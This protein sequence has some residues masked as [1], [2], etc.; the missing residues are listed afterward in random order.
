MREHFGAEISEEDLGHQA[1]QVAEAVK[2]LT[3]SHELAQILRDPVGTG[4]TAVALTAARLLLDEGAVDYVLVIAPNST[5]GDQWR[6]RAE[7]IFGER[8]AEGHDA[9]AKNKV[10]VGTHKTGPSWRSPK[11][12]RSL[13]IV[14]EAHRG[15]QNENSE[16]FQGVSAA[17]A[18]AKTLLVTA[19]PYQ[20][21]TTGFTRMLG[22][23]SGAAAPPDA[24][25]DLVRRYG[26]A[27]SKLLRR[28]EPD[29]DTSD[30]EPLIAEA[31][32]CRDKAAGVLSGRLLPVTGIRVPPAPAPS[33]TILPLGD[34]AVPYTVARV[35]P[36][37]IG[38]GRTDAFQRSLASSSETLT[39]SDRVVGR[40][41]DELMASGEPEVRAFL[42]Q[43]VD[44]MGTGTDHP[45]EAATVKW[46]KSQVADGHHVVV[47]T[48]WLP[49]R[50]AIGQ[51]LI[52]AG[53]EDVAAP[54][55]STVPGALESRFKADAGDRPV[56]L[57]LSDRFSESIDLDGGNPSIVH[58]DLTW[59]PIRLTQRWGRVVRIR[60]GFQPVPPDRIFLP[61]LDV[62]V[63]HRL[64]RVVTGRRD[65]AGLVVPESSELDADAWTMPDTILKRIA[66]NFAK[67][68]CGST[69]RPMSQPANILGRVR[70]DVAL[71]GE[72]ARSVAPTAASFHSSRSRETCDDRHR[73]SPVPSPP[74]TR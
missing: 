59:N 17:A 2:R 13:V 37:M 40:R 48:S 15:L 44:R 21:T 42:E 41:I 11:P 61:I 64:A 53:M 5:V 23:S 33:P 7:P 30:I 35:L 52:E 60:T 31:E 6:K 12:A 57:V 14:D 1:A 49:T 29:V 18:G 66:T 46:V 65:L 19:T 45:K 25:L 16:A 27:T 71:L 68:A 20:L 9:W 38:V 54:T 62:E 34:W 8:I 36:E 50:G 47:F 63:D 32:R 73:R 4:K 3:R 56:V 26:Q 58:H 72:V 74:A 22:V 10:V 24:D 55:G 51:A 70:R 67:Q 43:L 69:R 28:W 39:S